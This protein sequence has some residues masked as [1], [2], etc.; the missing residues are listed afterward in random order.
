VQVLSKHE[1][2]RWCRSH[3]IA[4][5]AHRHPECSDLQRRFNIP[6]G[7]Q[8]RVALV[9]RAM[10]A[11]RGERQVLVW[12]DDWSVWP[13]GQRMHVFDRFRMS[14]G[15]TRPLIEAPGH[16]FKDTEIEDAIS[17]VTIAVL[18]LWDCFV[19]TPERKKLLW[20]SHDEIGGLKGF[21]VEGL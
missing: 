18:F 1:T 3:H 16:L 15:E 12:F 11:F 19:V 7:A 8:K 17:M 5:D 2:T 21:R 4:L 20:F 6:P 10:E 13:A 14:Y 9:T